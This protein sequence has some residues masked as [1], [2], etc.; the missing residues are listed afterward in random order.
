MVL[1][2]DA[3]K[4]DA[5]LSLGA[6]GPDPE[7]ARERKAMDRALDF[8]YSPGSHGQGRAGLGEPGVYLPQWLDLVRTSFKPDVVTMLFKDALERKGLGRLLLEPEALAHL[9]PSPQLVATL[10]SLKDL[11]PESARVPIRQIVSRLVQRLQGRMRHRL[12]SAVK[13]GLRRVPA[14]TGSYR[15]IDWPRTIRR[16]LRHYSLERKR[17]APERFFFRTGERGASDWRLVLLVDQSGS[18]AESVV[19]AAVAASVL[20]SVRTLKTNLALFGT[21]IADVSDVASDPVAVLVGAQ[22]GG[23]T[24][25]AAAVAYARQSL[26]TNPARTI[27]VLV[28]DLY[29]GGDPEALLAGLSAL[30]ESHCRTACILAINASGRA[31][32]D[33]HMATELE[34]IGTPCCAASPDRLVDI[35]SQLWDP[36]WPPAGPRWHGAVGGAR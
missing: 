14:S 30:N 7:S 11:A 22:I 8:V 18:M 15:S 12:V 17:M 34:A 20:A 27:L 28:S 9:E 32:Y 19:H 13:Q 31:D 16:N 6:D 35:V 26:V 10:L 23:G 25:I 2:P 24:D 4:A 33:E 21:E 1:G 36:V 5:R 29:E 3:E